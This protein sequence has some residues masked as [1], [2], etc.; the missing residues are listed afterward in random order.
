MCKYSFQTE[1]VK[2]TA[3]V[4]AAQAEAENDRVRLVGNSGGG[5]DGGLDNG[6]GGDFPVVVHGGDV[7]ADRVQHLVSA[8]PVISPQ[9]ETSQL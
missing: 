2:R 4:V 3:V 8:A 9:A 1:V 7:G 6:R 5:I